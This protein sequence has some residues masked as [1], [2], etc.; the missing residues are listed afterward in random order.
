MIEMFFASFRRN[1]LQAIGRTFFLRSR[2]GVT[3]IDA[4]LFILACSHKATIGISPLWRILEKR[5]QGRFQQSFTATH[6]RKIPFDSPLAKGET[7]T[8]SAPVTVIIF[9]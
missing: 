8:S 7:S 6:L 1:T 9:K 3:K 4:C 5:G 2:W